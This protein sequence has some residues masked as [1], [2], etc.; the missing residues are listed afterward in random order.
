MTRSTAQAN[1]AIKV[2]ALV[3]AGIYLYRRFTEGT[4]EELKA[5][6]TVTPL[7]RF[8]IGWSVVFFGLSVVAGPFPGAAGDLAILLALGSLLTNGV[9]VSKDLNKGLG[10]TTRKPTAQAQHGHESPTTE[11]ITKAPLETRTA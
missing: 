8:L 4:A 1:S 5:S 9:Q 2:A 6:T 3:V 7:P 10:A 11:N